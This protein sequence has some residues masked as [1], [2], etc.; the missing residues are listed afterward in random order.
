MKK[1]LG[2]LPFILLV[3]LVLFRPSHAFAATVTSTAT[4]GTWAT[5]STW[6]GG[7]APATGD[8]V[9]IATTGANAV[10]LA[11]SYSQ[12]AAGSVTVNSGATLNV[13]N[14]SGQTFVFGSL[15]NNGTMSIKRTF[16][17]TG[18]TTVSGSMY[19]GS[20]STSARAIK[21]SG[22]VT[23]NSGAI[24]NEAK[25]DSGTT[26]TVADTFTF[27]GN[28]TNN[29][30]TF[31]T[32][33][34][35]HTFSGSAKSISGSTA[36]IIPNVAVTVTGSTASYTNS[37]ALTVGTALSGT[38]T[39]INSASGT[40]NIGGTSAITTLT[41][42]ASGNTV[43]YTGAA[44]TVKATT[45][46]NLTLSG[47]AAKSIATGTSITG[48]LSIAP[49]GAAIA[50]IGAGLS[51]SV[52][53]LKLAG[54]T[55]ASGTWGSTSSSATN[56]T[57]TYFAATTG[58]LNV[59]TIN[60]T[61]TNITSST[62]NGSYKAGDTVSV[63]VTFS[64]TVNVT[65]TPQLTLETGT[66]DEA[67]N[68]TSGSGSNT[69]TFTYTVQAGDTT[70]D[71]DYVA[72]TSLALH[73]G[74]I[75]DLA[76]NPAILTLPS[77]AATGSLG[78]N[79]AIVIDTTAPTITNI[80]SSLANGSYKA[81]Q[82]I[83]VAFT[84]SEAVTSTGS[85]VVMFDT[86]STCSFTV[87]S[88]TAASCNY[89]VQ[90]GDSSSDLTVSGVSGTIKD[91]TQNAMTSFTPA[92][93]LADNKAIVIDTT[94]PT[95]TGVTSSNADGSYKSG[96][97]ITIQVNFSENVTVSGI[98]RLVLKTGSP[99]TTNISY[100]GGSGTSTLTFTY[101]VGSRNYSSHLDYASTGSL[102]FGEGD[103]DGHG[104]NSIKD[105][106]GNLASIVLP[107]PGGAGSLF[108]NK[109]L[110]INTSTPAVSLTST[111]TT[112]TNIAI[113]VKAV[114]STAMTGFVVGDISVTNG[115]AGSFSGS[116][117]TYTFTVT[118]TSQGAVTVSLLSGV[119]QDAAGN[120]NSASNTLSRTYDSVP[121]SVSLTTSTVSPTL[122]TPISY[123]ATF[124]E[125]VTGF[126]LSDITS[127]N[128][129]IGNFHVVSSRVYTFDVSPISNPIDNVDV[130]TSIASGKAQDAAGNGNTASDSATPS[131][132][133]F[134]NHSPTV[135]VSTTAT[136]PTGTTPIPVTIT[137]SE[138]VTG[139][140]SSEISV[141]NATIGSFSGSGSTY[142]FNAIPSSQ[143]AVS[144]SIASGVASDDA[145]NTNLA[146][147]VLSVSYDS[148]PPTVVL[149][150]VTASPTNLSPFS[151]TATFSEPVTGFLVG[152]LSVTNGTADNFSGVDG[153]SV[154]TFDITPSG[155]G[156][157][158]ISVPVS[159]AQDLASNFNTTPSNTLS[160]TYDTVPS[161]LAEVT[162]V[163]VLG[164]DTT[165]NYTFSSTKAGTIV[166][167]G[168]CNSTTT[169]AS[170]GSNTVTFN[171]L[172]SATYND[173]S[174]IVT[175]AAGNESD[176]LI[177]SAFTI[178]TSNPVVTA[179]SPTNN[180]TGI[181]STSNLVLTFDKNV[182]VGTGNITIKKAS[183]DTT[184]EAIDVTSGQVT[185][186][187]TSTLTIDPSVT[188]GSQTTYYVQIAS[189]A[190]VD[191]FGNAFAGIATT[192]TWKF[193]TADTI[194]PSISVLSPSDLSVGVSVNP[195][196]VLTFSEA[197]NVHAGFITIRNA[198]DNTIAEDISAVS[199]Q[200]TGTG[201]NVITVVP[202]ITLGSQTN[203]YVEIGAT[204]FT[205][206]SGN[207]FAGISSSTAWRFTTV[208]TTNPFTT[209]LSPA[210][211]STG[212][213]AT[214]NLVMTFDRVIFA[215][216]G[217][218]VIKK[219]S[220]NTTVETISATSGQVVVSGSPSTVTINPN[221]TLASQTS[222]YVQLDAGTFNDTSAG[223]GNAYEGIADSTTWSFTTADTVAPTL[224][225]VSLSSNNASSTH[226][227]VGDTITLSF[228]SSE[229]ISSPTV[230]FTSGGSPVAN[231]ITVTNT[232]GND[233]IASYVASA[234]DTNGTIAYSI[235][236]FHDASNNAGLTVSSGSG[237]VTFDKSIP[238]LS[239][240]SL[241]SDNTATTLAKAGNVITLTFTSSETISTPS[242]SFQSGGSSVTNAISVNNPSGNHWSASYT[243]SASD[244][245]GSITYSIGSFHDTSYNDGLTVSSGL[246]TVT[247]DKTAP[248][249]SAATPETAAVINN[250][251]T[252]SL[253]SF[254]TS[255]NL[256]S[257]TI[258]ITR[259]SGAADGASPHVC[260]LT[261][262]ALGAGN[263]T[264]DLSDTTNGCT[265]DQSNLVST[266]VY[267]FVFAG[268]DAAGNAATPV[269]HTGITFNSASPTVTYVTSTLEN[270]TYG[271]G[272]DVDVEVTFSEAVTS[273][274]NVTVTF[275]TGSTDRT[276][277]FSIASS[278]TGGCTYTVQAGD[279]S[280]DLNVNSVTGT[281]E[282]S[283]HKLVENF[284][285]AT[286]LANNKNI[287]I[288]AVGP[289][290]SAVAPT[291][292]TEINNVT[293]ASLIAFTTNEALGS[294]TI[295]MTRTSGSA[296]VSSP[297]VCSLNGSA[298]LVGSHVID[299]S[300]TTNG[301]VSDVS[302]LVAESVYTFVFAGSD[303]IGNAA[304]TVTRTGV[305]FHTTPPVLNP[306]TLSS[307]NATSS[308]A[309]VGDTVTLA[310]TSD[311]PITTPTVVMRSGGQ[312]VADE[313]IVSNPTGNDWTAT[314]VVRSSDTEGGVTFSISGAT[315]DAGNTTPPVTSG[316]GTVEVDK[317][318]PTLSAVS[319]SSSNA[320]STQSKVG[321]T[322]T[323][324]FTASESVSVPTVIFT[325]GGDAI[326]NA[327]A[328][329]VSNVSG[330]NWTATYVTS[331][332]D[333]EGDVAYS[334]SG[335]HDATGNTGTSV[336]SG[337]GTVAFNKSLP[338][339]SAVALA[340]NN[341]TTT[342]A[343]VGDVVHVSFTTSESV[344]KPDVA[345]T[346][347]GRAV[348]NTVSVE[349]VS[350]NDWIA[351]YT[352][353]TSDTEGVIAY[354]ISAFHDIAG[355][356][357]E[358]VSEG[359]GTVT[360]SKTA[361]VL[362]PVTLSSNNDSVTHAKVGDTVTLAFTASARISMPTVVFRSGGDLVTNVISVNEGE[363]NTWT[364]SYDT[365]SSD[366]EG[367]ITYDIRDYHDAAH[368]GG[369][370]V[371]SGSGSVTFDKV[372]PSLS[373][374]ALSSNNAS[375]L[376][377]KVGDV[378]T[379]AF[380]ASEQIS[381]PA[382]VF[383]TGGSVVHETVNVTH[384]SGVH[385]TATFTLSSSDISGAVTYGIRNYYD[386]S[387]NDGLTVTTGSGSVAYRRSAPSVQD[388]VFPGSVTQRGGTA[389]SIHPTDDSTNTIWF[390][391]FGTTEFADS[392]TMT[393][394]AGDAM[395]IL[396]PA[397]EGSYAI[398]VVDLSSNISTASDARL[399]VDNTAPILSS[400]SFEPSSGVVKTGETVT[401]HIQA[402]HAGY[403]AGTITINGKS[404]SDF[405]DNEDGTYSVTYVV[406]N[407]DETILPS[408]QLSVSVTLVDAA[409][410][411]SSPYTTSPSSASSP[412]I[413]GNADT[414]IGVSIAR[415][416]GQASI[417]HVFPVDFT[418]V[419]D[420]VI[421]AHSF[422]TSDVSQDGTASELVWGIVDSG[423]HRH[424]TV[425]ASSATNG[426]IIPFIGV[427][428]V[429]DAL[430]N[431]N[432]ASSGSDS[433]TIDTVSPGVSL[434]TETVSPTNAPFV[435]TATFTKSV[436][437][438][439]GD[440]VHVTNGTVSDFAAA[441][442]S[443][444]SFTVTP[445]ADGT[446]RVNIAANAAQDAAGNESTAATELTMSFL[447][448][449]PVMSLVT[450]TPSVTSAAIT[451]TTNTEASSQVKYSPDTSFA[452]ESS[453]E[454]TEV[455]VLS[456]HVSLTG[457][458]ACTAYKFELLSTDGAG[459]AT[460]DSTDHL[461]TT[462]GCTGSSEV[463]S[464][465]NASVAS[466]ET[467]TTSL[468]QGGTQMHVETPA[469]FTGTSS[470]VIQIKAISSTVVVSAVGKPTSAL[471]SVGVVAFDVKALIN[472]VTTLDSFDLP[473]TMTYHYSDS[474]VSGLQESSIWMYHYHA[475]VW[476]AL[477]HCVVDT[478]LN[479][480]TC[481][482]PSFSVFSIFGTPVAAQSGGSS[483]GSSGTNSVPVVLPVGIIQPKP[484][485]PA[486]EVPHT[487]PVASV[488]G[489]PVDYLPTECPET[490]ETIELNYRP[491]L[492]SDAIAF[493]VKV[494]DTQLLSATHFV[495][496]GMSP[497]TIKLGSGER[498]ALIR[499]YY[500]TVQRGDIVWSDIQRLT[501]GQKLVK[502]NLANEQARAERTLKNFK[503]F[504]P[505]TPNFTNV[506]EDLAW[507]TL[508]YR[509]R[510]SRDLTKEKNG[511]LQFK[512][513]Y[514][515]SP[516]T[517]L[518]WAVVR[519]IGYAMGK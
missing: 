456:H 22:D 18:A 348:T 284:V 463:I 178:N 7:V 110:V 323:L 133:R 265:T 310:F 495:A 127:T 271:V 87:A 134:D 397:V 413:N 209:A 21:F 106:T 400:V 235:S 266:T 280:S 304:N 210:N 282:D 138:A 197:V 337:S 329:L 176:P 381:A 423:D 165:P 283:A 32:L 448:E 168:S 510:F 301:C 147:N 358:T 202:S 177:V 466:D 451:W 44:Q 98:P 254:T 169:A 506:Q 224:S 118:P 27:A 60:A 214:A 483:G 395:S 119:A 374:V 430:E 263:H 431:P 137:F 404:I 142:T 446:V 159:S 151:V 288:D 186:S 476:S 428:H 239:S 204:V 432:R 519:A 402:D 232:S 248:V 70:S 180:A 514:K 429:L 223:D 305:I 253:V 42:S 199:G 499:D 300:D 319:I 454:D 117:T 372:I 63:Q 230:S 440:Q 462:T 152:A 163:A 373:S 481:T 188:L 261:G 291:S 211:F 401:M 391:P 179:F 388:D 332:A 500:E 313:I 352:T 435:V 269:T 486:A 433:V 103:G 113:P 496:C 35:T 468:T 156:P 222:Y 461:F 311:E 275:E 191:T 256:A 517:P 139:F 366:T 415:K 335:F 368:N 124:S 351:T 302:H 331:S 315:D 473:V 96:D 24:W 371:T 240:V 347:G 491:L 10:T 349:L 453:V 29:A 398:Y 49:T 205:D 326:A 493:H 475:G 457:L 503:M 479:T 171:T 487:E 107:A 303:A 174:I 220:D 12:T 155:Q 196:F 482:T 276:C 484:V 437:G 85:V 149:S 407:G 97:V 336:I 410:N 161:V 16:T 361:P 120:L 420:S 167:G 47:S 418:V 273:T 469:G 274:G 56:K 386:A 321:D 200:V 278:S 383:R 249:F 45:Y 90:S 77:P 216:A 226:A 344:S 515:R 477:D 270:G 258:T 65:G 158:S 17:V 408:D 465:T 359:S 181:S 396:A 198:L 299:L 164:T 293:S 105:A 346:S 125:A 26:N 369:A 316:T 84:F 238:T 61:V 6:V 38:G 478:S 403:H 5:G 424:F 243:T 406:E 513:L 357:G 219:T 296:D 64:Q 434:S 30:S 82:I 458:L 455:R 86:G 2:F 112:L 252:S 194:A 264:I 154:Y 221:S 497:E 501:V 79:K 485:V 272:Q 355:N 387:N 193:T 330:N 166:Y 81:G 170:I 43:N 414:T 393:H 92:T 385:W 246:G 175:D 213:S 298:L 441:S 365:S 236:S 480:I 425:S 39:L 459:N 148:G 203:Y 322:I 241:S 136:D 353:S 505:H 367:L 36:M 312:L 364:A 494:T 279:S 150:T 3:V 109:A 217:N 340:S 187:G 129:S 212:I 126:T 377:A 285:P 399:T 50:S 449:G 257:G 46:S 342:E 260:T 511:I 320:T 422:T 88:N 502:R 93:N 102:T 392:P 54:T 376:E 34:G 19:Y 157:V 379:L 83:P 58:V 308:L 464:Q 488:G 218:I 104:T 55:Q 504:V 1:Q 363:G 62:S 225:A 318:A 442:D 290:F 289:V 460:I 66:T 48:T 436:S 498:R 162:P 131:Y 307:S 227:K 215:Q 195:S 41:A 121:P 228:T 67:V 72:T 116:G 327:D 509:I 99:V 23:L 281:I 172:A 94:G 4:G 234:S 350:G 438:F 262:T 360:F 378:I 52:S 146:S 11:A 354:V 450:V 471:N 394:S 409:G 53:T 190:I 183:D 277:T 115:T 328:V 135:A 141:S 189:T 184:V 325:A 69:L 412:A 144:V 208:N 419:F 416:E 472:S 237:S 143:G 245:S 122:T 255:E 389:V 71:L 292:S 447:G 445:T 390:A 25:S 68:Y 382:V 76:S 108:A 314:Y 57:N 489:S 507:N 33:A 8:A 297:H 267:T 421:D 51:I 192:N 242:V 287:V 427:G 417:T 375:P 78:A 470:V 512:S 114:F 343:K 15:V 231:A 140:L 324:S 130:Y 233:W 182:S 13:G 74:T 295:T 111:S 439:S 250:V 443:V 444:Y 247:F 341:E 28:L 75:N 201:T 516:V 153:D 338:T 207:A 80:T 14:G 356:V 132:I 492:K 160:V 185:G 309:K 490:F 333:T 73:G 268:T 145:L 59:S 9:V 286:N 405:M 467:H 384:G 508:M 100:T 518:E 244:A 345:F 452:S 101:T 251:S 411:E 20:T 317:T 259:T 37:A 173:C 362:D 40:L 294:G 339:L 91:A 334:I 95:I 128:A 229:T 123:T 306:V 206:L 31:T 474:D 370:T 89:T 380:E 426:T